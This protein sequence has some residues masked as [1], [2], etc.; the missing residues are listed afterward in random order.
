MRWASFRAGLFLFCA[1]YPYI[2]PYSFYPYKL[3]FDIRF[4]RWLDLL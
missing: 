4:W 3:P 1:P 2:Y